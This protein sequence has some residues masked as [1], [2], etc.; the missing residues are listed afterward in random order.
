[1][2]AVELRNISKSFDGKLVLDNCD[3]LVEKGEIH[4][5]LG[6]NGAGKS[7][8]MNIL[9]GLINK[10]GGSVKIFDKVANIKSTSDAFSYGIGMVHQHF[11]LLEE[12]TVLE[13]IILGNEIGKFSIDYE[14]NFN[15]V[16]ELMDD[17]GIDIN[18][19]VKVKNLSVGMKQR[20]EIIKALYRGGELLILDEP[21]AVLTEQEINS[22]INT[23]KK[24][25]QAGKTI[26]FITHKLNETKTI[27]D[28]ATVLRRGKAIK[29]VDVDSVS[30]KDLANMMVGKNVDPISKETNV[31]SDIIFEIK[32]LE[33][34]SNEV[35][36][37]KIRK[38]EI[39][40]IAGV[41]GNGQ[42]ELE[43][44]IMGL[45]KEKG[46]IFYDNKNINS[47]TTLQRKL[48]GIGHIPS[49]RFKRAIL[50]NLKISE[51]MILGKDNNRIINFKNIESESINL[52]D[53]YNVRYGMIDD[54]ISSLSGGNQ[55]KVVVAREMTGN[56]KLIIAAQPSRGLDIGA[57][58]FIYEKF[59]EFVKQGNSILLI[60][61][62]LQEIQTLADTIAVMYEGKFMCV[63]NADKISREEIGLMMAGKEVIYEK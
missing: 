24:L 1:M 54:N 57:M 41:D 43:E 9:I 14:C 8:I 51:N 28:R 18:L 26:I 4:C 56:K 27:A 7:T 61:A 50:P 46:D 25:K 38:G 31:L 5:L 29:T 47:F 48:A 37:F 53:E 35:I 55:Q 62:D 44:F 45:R 60:S 2:Y 58:N 39:F 33:L 40:A 59:I 42:S 11:M 19:N 52:L 16:K 36:N 32:N 17:Y 20:V 21:T 15:K 30:E 34:H 10:D 22:L 12:M 3:L 63:R 23:M 13:N 6:E 49:D